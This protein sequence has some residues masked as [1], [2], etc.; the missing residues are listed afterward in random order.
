MK[1]YKDGPKCNSKAFGQYD[2]FC[3]RCGCELK[4]HGEW[5]AGI[6]DYAKSMLIDFLEK[7]PDLAQEA[8]IGEIPDRATEGICANGN[9]MFSQSETRHVL[10]ECWNEVEIALDSWRESN[11]CD[12]PVR[13]IEHL[14]VFSVVQ[15]AEM[16]WR[17]IINDMQWEHL[18]DEAITEAVYRLK[19]W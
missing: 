2:V 12:Y 17:S 14:H 16:V 9:I 5:L 4:D 3:S 11:G 19:N 15:H 1:L 18:D 10:A 8:D 6:C 7:C 13:N